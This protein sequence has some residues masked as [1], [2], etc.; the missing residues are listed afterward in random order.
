MLSPKGFISRYIVELNLNKV[1]SLT[2]DQGII[3]RVL[4]CGTVTVNGTGGVRTVF[5]SIDDPLAFRRTV[6]TQLEVPIKP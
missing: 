4:N 1:E 2:V 5:K 6:N 3:G